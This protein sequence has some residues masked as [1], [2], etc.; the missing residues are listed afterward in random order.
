MP[1][2]S[3]WIQGAATMARADAGIVIEDVFLGG[4][5]SQQRWQDG[6]HRLSN[7]TRRT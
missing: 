5:A 7:M 4:A 1:L 2:Q 3:A 6:G